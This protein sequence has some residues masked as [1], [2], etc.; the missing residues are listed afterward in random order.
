V[1]KIN[2]WPL[3]ACCAALA[4]SSGQVRAAGYEVL[5]QSAEAQGTAQ[6]G[7]GARADDPSTAFFNPAGMT[8]LPGNQISGNVTGIFL[9][10]TPE[11]GSASTASYMGGMPYATKPGG[12]AGLAAALP[13]LYATAQLKDT[14]FAGLAITSPFGL[15]TK[16][17]ADSIASNYALTTR[18]QTINIG[19]TLAWKVLPNF[20]IAAGLNVEIAQGHRSNAVDFGA[21][22]AVSGLAAFGY[23]PGTHIGAATI[24]GSDTAVGWNVGALYEPLP[25]TRVASPIVQR[26][27]M[28]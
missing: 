27:F 4:L 22:G 26:Y 12:N 15:V 1:I 8:M 17:G 2:V 19:P 13:D 9:Q 3:C 18:L 23:L 6:A 7:A 21:V 28:T 16:Y 14:L 20:S 25:G 5:E 24:N 11:T 10:T